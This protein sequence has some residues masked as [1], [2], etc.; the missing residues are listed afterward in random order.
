MTEHTDGRSQPKERRPESGPDKGSPDRFK[1]FVPTSIAVDHQTSVIVLLIFLTVAGFL[2]YRAIPRESFPAIEI[3]MIAVNTIYPGVSPA[4]VESLVTR[5]LEDELSTISDM[6]EMTSTSVEGYSSIISEFETTVNL[7]EALQL[8]REKVDLAKPD[9]P[10]EAEDPSILEFNFSE[11]PIMQVNLSGQYGLV[12]LKEIGEDLQD[13]LE[14]IPSVLRAEIRGG[15]ARE[16]KVDVHLDRL[17]FYGLEIGDLIEA[18]RGE[19]VNIPGG[20]IDVGSLKYLVRVDG[21]FENPVAIEDVVVAIE[22]DR[23][24]YVR[25]IA[26][27]EF[28]FQERTSFA[29]LDSDPVVTLDIVKRSGRNIIETADLVKAVIL[30]MEPNFPPTTVVKITS[31]QSAQISDMVSSLENNII[32]GLILIIGVLLFFLGVGNSVFVAISIPASML[33]SFIIMQFLGITLNMVVLFS[34]ILALG[35]LVDNAIVIVENIYRYVEEGWDRRMAAKKATGEVAMPVIAAT[36]TTLAAFTPLLFWPGQVGEFMKFLPST[37]IITLS[38]SLFVALVIVPTLCAM[39]LR[40]ED[41]P[42]LPLRSAARWTMIGAVALSFLGLASQNVLT[43]AMLA[44]TILVLY[45]LHHVLIAGMAHRF[46]TLWMPG[47]L[48]VYEVQLRF[49]LGHRALVVFGSFAGLIV[50]ILLFARFNAGIVF[51]PEDMPPKQILID[52]NL[53]VGSRA[54]ATDRIARRLENDIV[55][56]AGMADAESVV[57]TVGGSGGGGGGNPMAGGASGPDAGRVTVS[58]VEFGSQQLDPFDLLATMQASL[59]T[60]IAGAEITIDQLQEGPAQGAPVNIEIIGEDPTVLDRLS[61]RALEIL[62]GDPI[63]AKLVGLES[64]LDDARPELAVSVDRE[65]AALY[66]VSS[67]DVGMAIRGAIQGIEAAKYRDG[68]EEYDIV[69]RLAEKYR[70]ELESLRDLTVMNDGAQIPLLSV[71]KWEVADGYGSIR[72]KDQT[73]MATISSDVRAG[74]NSNAVLREVRQVLSDFSSSELPVGYQIRYTG[75]SQDQDEAAAFLQSAF[76]GAVMLIGLILVTQ[77]NS[78]VK[79]V[80]ILTSVFMSTAGVLLGLVVFRMPF[81][82][83]MTGVGVISLAG[84]VVNNAIVLLDYIDILRTRDG[85]DREEALVRGG[86]VRFRP[87]VLTAITTALGLIPL[88]IGLNFDFFGLYTRLEPELYWGGEQAAWWGPMAIAVI[89]GIL[90]ATF[91]TLDLVPVLY[92]IVDDV[93]DF[94][95][96]NFTRIDGVPA[97]DGALQRTRAPERESVVPSPVLSKMKASNGPS[98]MIPHPFLGRTGGFT[99]HRE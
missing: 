80:I 55:T 53:P 28:G 16:V 63:Y 13:R 66:G 87:V 61:H 54:E 33:L 72:R 97:A 18:I 92:S 60:D 76:F 50:A 38:S 37:L 89:V 3:P 75:Q 1:E 59:G 84:I 79:P 34:L 30:Q 39:F 32:S 36:L 86:H 23:P 20:S 26:D 71:A 91:L 43:A 14:Q 67:R 48:R 90:F 64:D 7:E 85:M 47:I 57:A 88:A 9:L 10:V 45:A 77:F 78:V 22:D 35:M 15:L 44:G 8:V 51:F 2:A 70:G 5:P 69:V 24:I 19:H 65:K 17:Q 21:E 58:L 4:D 82:I 11:F 31:D 46:Q 40:L 73:R 41:D 83:I 68:N 12:R 29:R 96:R 81:G 49:A 56:L 25:D 6:R 27:V 52:M 98:P 99:P 95:R 62:E 93:A 74:L 94:F 42:V